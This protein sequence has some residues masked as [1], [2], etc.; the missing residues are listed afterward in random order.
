[1]RAA[2]RPAHRKLNRVRLG[3]FPGI[4]GVFLRVESAGNQLDNELANTL[5][6]F[7]P[8]NLLGARV[9]LEETVPG[10]WT[11]GRFYT[12]SLRPRLGTFLSWE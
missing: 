10:S 6:R 3:G 12:P 4:A 11:P 5:A 2:C 9:V 7:Q 1:M 8:F